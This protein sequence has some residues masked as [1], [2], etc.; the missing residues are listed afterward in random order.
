[1][2]VFLI[3]VLFAVIP[4]TQTK[5]R[6]TLFLLAALSADSNK[7]IRRNHQRFECL[8]FEGQIETWFNSLPVL[9]LT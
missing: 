6:A 3:S 7:T 4:Y 9:R 1:M 8:L 5:K 2:V